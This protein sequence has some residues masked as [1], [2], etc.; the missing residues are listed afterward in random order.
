MRKWPSFASPAASVILDSGDLILHFRSVQ[1]YV[2]FF[3]TFF[4]CLL[5]LTSPRKPC[6]ST[7]RVLAL[8]A[9]LAV[10][11]CERNTFWAIFSYSL[12]LIRC[13]KQCCTERNFV[14]LW[15]WIT[16]Q[17]EFLNTIN[18]WEVW[19][20]VRCTSFIKPKPSILWEWTNVTNYNHYVIFMF[21]WFIFHSSHTLN[22][23]KTPGPDSIAPFIIKFCTSQ[24]APSVTYRI[25]IRLTVLLAYSI[26]GPWEWALIQFSPFLASVGVYFAT[27]SFWKSY[28]IKNAWDW[29]RCP[30]SIQGANAEQGL[31]EIY[32]AG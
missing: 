20:H 21:F 30:R 29:N 12:C 25:F 11:F 8:I 6:N 17:N 3:L 13:W 15:S 4:V 14:W 18:D 24:M 31:S 5:F 10:S 19:K 23:N 16:P 28:R 9:V 32:C 22:P 27:K 7:P 26:F 2:G 1:D